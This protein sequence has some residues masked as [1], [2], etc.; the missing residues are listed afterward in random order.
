[1]S[2]RPNVSPAKP[3]KRRRAGRQVALPMTKQ[4]DVRTAATTSG[5]ELPEQ[6]LLDLVRGLARSAAR[7]L[8]RRSPSEAVAYRSDE[9]SSGM[10]L[11]RVPSSE[12][13]PPP[14]TVKEVADYL[15]VSADVVRYEIKHK[16]L[17]AIKVGGQWRIFPEDLTEYVMSQLDKE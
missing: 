12:L 5:G 3:P 1:V 4:S 11:T 17:R 7:E 10:M 16:R 13:G 9:N 6:A 14:L 2:S 8:A 15:G